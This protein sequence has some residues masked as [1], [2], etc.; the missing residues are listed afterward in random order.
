[1]WRGRRLSF[2]GTGI[3]PVRMTGWKLFEFEPQSR[4]PVP[5]QMGLFHSPS[6]KQPRWDN[7]AGVPSVINNMS[8]P[9]QRRAQGRARVAVLSGSAGTLMIDTTR[10][11]GLAPGDSIRQKHARVWRGL[12]GLGG[13]LLA[14]TF[15]MPAVRGCSAPIVPVQEVQGVLTGIDSHDL[16]ELSLAFVLYVAAYL[17][18]VLV[19]AAAL[20]RLSRGSAGRSERGWGSVVLIGLVALLLVVLIAVELWG[21]T[22]T[23]FTEFDLPLIMALIVCPGAIGYQMA[24]V[25][26]LGRRAY[27]AITFISASVAC[28]WF[29]P[30][31]WNGYYGVRL[32][33]ASSLLILV[34]I[35]GESVVLTRRGWLSTVW[36][37]ATCR[38]RDANLPRAA[39][40]KC[41]Y[42]LQGLTEMRCPECGRPFSFDELGL[43]SEDLG[44]KERLE[45][46]APG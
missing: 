16:L 5:Q 4:R 15:F 38:L 36:R 9:Q 29:G 23:G 32:S 25:L 24:A 10:E 8:S 37:L 21:S 34:G 30:W 14:S 31:V 6:R 12:I 40:P 35:I 33:F 28:I 7:M 11:P 45:V 18:G 46:H 39:C 41:E 26:R 22:Y 44:Y 43:S 3:L 13:L 17:W 1:M 2:C 20:I 27:L 19:G 42:D